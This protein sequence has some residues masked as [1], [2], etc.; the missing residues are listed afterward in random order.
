M[1]ILIT[2]RQL[3]LFKNLIT[4]PE[5]EVP[6]VPTQLTDDEVFKIVLSGFKLTKANQ[7]F[8]HPYTTKNGKP[9]INL[10]QRI[11]NWITNKF[12]YS[13]VRANLELRNK[14]IHF[15]RKS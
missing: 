12:P 2:E 6:E 8:G 4:Q 10:V 15:F 11:N 7:G 14:T 5:V 9:T 3:D 13:P 1:D